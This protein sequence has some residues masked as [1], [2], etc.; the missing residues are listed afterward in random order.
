M[1]FSNENVVN[2]IL[3]YGHTPLQ[4]RKRWIW[5]HVQWN[6]QNFNKK[7]LLEISYLDLNEQIIRILKQKIKKK[8]KKIKIFFKV[9]KVL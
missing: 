5:A 9:G 3:K 6:I 2:K 4:R 8:S 1:C 7:K